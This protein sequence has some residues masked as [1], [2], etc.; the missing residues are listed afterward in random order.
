MNNKAIS[1]IQKVEKPPL[2][3]LFSAWY[4][5]EFHPLLGNFVQNHAKAIS[6][7]AKVI[8]IHPYEN[9]ESIQKQKFILEEK[10]IDNL[11]EIRIK[12]KGIK[13]KT[14][15]GK[16]VRFIRTYKAYKKGVQ[17]TTQ[18][19]GIPDIS[20]VNVLTRSALPAL[21]LKRKYNVPFI[22][23]EHWTRYL[24]ENNSFKGYF[25]KKFVRCVAKQAD[26]ITVV[27]SQLKQAM[28]NHGLFNTNYQVISNVIDETIFKPFVVEKQKKSILHISALNDAHKN[29]SGILRVTKLLSQKRN[30]FELVIIGD[31]GNKASAEKFAQELEIL[32]KFVFFKGQIPN[33]QLPTYINQSDFHL[34]FSNFETQGL[35]LIES[36]ACG[37]PVIATH[38]GGVLDIV[39]KTNGI[40]VNSLNEKELLN[41][42]DYM[43][44]HFQ[45]YDSEAIHNF[46]IEN[47]SENAIGQKFLDIYRKVL[48]Q[49]TNA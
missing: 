28:L 6:K 48:K 1:N 18:N 41:V 21:K 33:E 9:I 43:L 36:F 46:A 8:V 23:T 31:E 14:Y 38:T 39:N 45:E 37:K 26:T 29:I 32:D 19:Y 42:I 5:T 34:L 20:H 35:V 15:F 10:Q 27:S 44:D 4:P 11:I 12:F 40:L 49:N 30:D 3:F 2:I 16:L 17:F 25:R 22:I 47:F 24:P 13:N 7:F